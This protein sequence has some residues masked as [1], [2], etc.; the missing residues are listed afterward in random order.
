MGSDGG[1]GN[2]DG[3]GGMEG[4]AGGG[5]EGA[6]AGNGGRLGAGYRAWLSRFEGAVQESYG[7]RTADVQNKLVQLQRDVQD[8]V[9]A[10]KGELV[11]TANGGV[12][13]TPHIEPACNS[14]TRSLYRIPSCQDSHPL[15]LPF[16]D[17][18]LSL[19]SQRL[20]NHRS[21]DS[22]LAVMVTRVARR[23]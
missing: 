6:G 21:G 18:Y 14:R 2:G 19:Y 5:G 20:N 23:P 4:S 16:P 17:T 1:D 10:L 13:A 8:S 12:G 11:G 7:R 22:Y 9:D 3:A 15:L